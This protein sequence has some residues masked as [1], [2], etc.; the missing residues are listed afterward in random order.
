KIQ[1]ELGWVPQGDFVHKLSNTVH[2]YLTR[3]EREINI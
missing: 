3:Y 2:H 1:K